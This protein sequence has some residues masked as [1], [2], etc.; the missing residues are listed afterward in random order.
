MAEVLA[1]RVVTQRLLFQL[2][3]QSGDPHDILR[4]EHQAALADLARMEF[5]GLAPERREAVLA[6]AESVL[7]AI[8]TAMRPAEP[9]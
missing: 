9:R 7:D 4:Y 6:H 3:A 2:A 1:L 8:H 5:P